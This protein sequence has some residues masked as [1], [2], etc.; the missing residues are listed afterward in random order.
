[1]V[2][3]KPSFNYNDNN[4]TIEIDGRV[5]TAEP[6]GPG[7]F[8]KLKKANYGEGFVQATLGGQSMI[9][10]RTI[11]NSEAQGAQKIMHTGRAYWL[12]G[13]TAVIWT[14][15]GL[16]AQ[17]KPELREGRIYMVPEALMSQLDGKQIRDVRFSDEGK[18]RFTPYGFKVGEQKPSDFAKNAGLITLLGDE[19]EAELMAEASAKFRNK[20]FLGGFI[21]SQENLIRVPVLGEND[22]R[23]GIGGYDWGEFDD[24]RCSFGVLK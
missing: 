9:Y 15:E 10:S 23:L 12:L 24:D 17:D 19:E 22:D 18:V 16:I 6:Q 21:S 7:N 11:L 20:P 14:S 5:Y 3:A 8:L 4:G 1:M 2:R 13:D